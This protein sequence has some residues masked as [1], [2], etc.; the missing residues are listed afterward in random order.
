MAVTAN[1]VCD[2]WTPI[3]DIRQ[4]LC[5][6]AFL[7]NCSSYYSGINDAFSYHQGPFEEP[8]ILRHRC[9]SI[10][11]KAHSHCG[12]S[13]TVHDSLPYVILAQAV[14]KES[15]FNT[16]SFTTIAHII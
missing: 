1:D 11:S 14:Y 15:T 2:C 5:F 6:V 10:A 9:S 3:S 4:V 13:F 12:Y 7:S 16:L 8:L